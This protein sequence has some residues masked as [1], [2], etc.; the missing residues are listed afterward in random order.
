MVEMTQQIPAFDKASGNWLCLDF[1]HTLDDRYSDH[2][3][4]LLGSY[5]DLVFWSQYVHILK[6]E[7]AQHLFGE[8]ASRPAEAS[9]ALKRAIDVREIIYRVFLAIAEG[10]APEEVALTAFNAA[11]AE[12]LS[13]ACIVSRDGSFVLDWAGKE[14]AF[15]VILWE[16]VRSAADLLTAEELSAVRACAAED[17]KWL[18]LDTSK[19]RSRRWCDMKTCGNRNKAHRHYERKK[20][21]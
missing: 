8:A 2:P 4:E 3:K 12:A 17:C 14:D 5:R 20:Q 13:H 16:V 11:L 6:D 19:N 21:A 9:A 15:D 18:F 1:T 10:V 7:Q